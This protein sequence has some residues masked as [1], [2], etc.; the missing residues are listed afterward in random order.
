MILARWRDIACSAALFLLNLAIAGRLLA[1]EYLT[2]WGSV[3]PVFFAFARVLRR[4][5]PD[6]GLG[7][8]WWA[9][10]NLGYPLNYYYQPLLHLGV[11]AMTVLTGGNEARA[12]HIA[13]VIVY[14]AGPVS[15]YFLLR[16]FGQTPAVSLSAGAIYSL[17]SPAA[18]LLPQVRSE[19]GGIWL[20]AR[21]HSMS[22]YGDAPN[23]AGLALLPVAILMLDRA[24]ERRT[25][26]AWG[27]AAIAVASVPLTNFPAT[28]ALG[29]AL[30][31][32]G[33]ACDRRWTALKEI[34]LACGCGFLLFAPWLAPSVLLRVVGNTQQWMDR[35]ARFGVEKILYYA[36]F[37]VVVGTACVLLRRLHATF[38]AR[39]A[40][41]FLL[42]AAPVPLLNG[43]FGV[44]LIA[45]AHRFQLAM[46][47]PTAMCLTL[48]GAWVLRR[49]PYRPFVV[50]ILAAA[51]V[52]QTVRIA[53]EVQPWMVAG[54]PRGRPEFEISD[55]LEE[56]AAPGERVF[57]DGAVSLWVN[58]LSGV[59]Q[60]LGC[61][62]Q[63][64][65]I[66]STPYAHYL[67]Y[68]DDSAGDRAAEASI[69]WL[70]VLGVRYVAVNGPASLE[71]YR[72][73]VHPK[74]LDGALPERWR[75]GDDVIYEVPG[76]HASLVHAVR[77]EELPARD[78]I[79][80]LDLEAFAAYREAIMD[81]ARP[82]AKLT[83]E[84]DNDVRIVG[85]LKTGFVYSVQVPYHEGWRALSRAGGAGVT[86][87]PM[88]FL[89]VAP[90]CDGPCEVRL[91]FD[92]G[93]EYRVL[94]A[95]SALAWIGLF[96]WMWRGRGRASQRPVPMREASLS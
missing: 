35:A 94:K 40:V 85:E 91:H 53:R 3:E 39:F 79:H 6:L 89:V 37:A 11:A 56:H 70:Q 90:R 7:S 19:I 67:L 23:V 88:G 92:G 20:P 82:Q 22:I 13:L 38:A 34:A 24:R 26:W 93:T 25:A 4:R 65:L 9:G 32:Y 52:F 72:P 62:D 12:Y 80:G 1:I 55:W 10:S 41:L 31:A 15:G 64:H 69:A 77:P 57:V 81:A 60:V 58:Y 68:S 18:L 21:L 50:A 83:W 73:W 49:L 16:R 27:L 87:D 76:P 74:K 71:P 84:S 42:L 30:L 51:A 59:P 78:P 44:S 48:A 28:I 5:F 2:H 75:S 95:V 47:I 36:G 63:N 17:V 61:C 33:L 14:G 29:W 45:Q 8:T 86:S 54:D 46:E 66:R 96:T 43:W